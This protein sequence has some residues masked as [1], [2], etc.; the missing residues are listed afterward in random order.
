ML[1]LKSCP[2]VVKGAI[3]LSRHVGVPPPLGR[4]KSPSPLTVTL[5]LG[6]GGFEE[7]KALNH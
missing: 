4:F 2:D 5:Q 6:R 1:I 3:D 7:R